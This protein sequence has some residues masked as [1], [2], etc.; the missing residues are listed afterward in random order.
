MNMQKN[1]QIMQVRN[2]FGTIFDIIK[3]E[4]TIKNTNHYE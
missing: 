2:K 3:I 1:L 4:L